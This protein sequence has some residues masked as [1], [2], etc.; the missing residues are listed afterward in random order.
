[1]KYEAVAIGASAGGLY[2]LSELLKELPVD[3]P[4]PI[5]VIQHRS[6]EEKMLLEEILQLKCSIRVKQADEKE[7]IT[8]STVY[9]APADYHLLIEKN[10]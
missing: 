2:V 3:F 6:K 1:M 9:F 10:R 7:E 8:K 4:I 5:I